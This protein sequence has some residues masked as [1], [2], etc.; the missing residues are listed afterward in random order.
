MKLSCI[1]FG[2]AAAGGNERRERRS[3]ESVYSLNGEESISVLDNILA[4]VTSGTVILF[5]LIFRHYNP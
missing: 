1:L 5:C 3:I 4:N 2:L